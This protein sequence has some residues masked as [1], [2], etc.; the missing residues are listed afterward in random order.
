MRIA[1]TSIAI[2]FLLLSLLVAEE[3]TVLHTPS[4]Q[5]EFWEH[6]LYSTGKSLSCYFTIEIVAREAGDPKNRDRYL[7]DDEEVTSVDEVID[8]VSKN[9]K[10]FTFLKN[11]KNPRIV[12]IIDND[13]RK[14]PDYPIDQ[15]MDLE[16][17][18]SLDELSIAIEKKFPTLGPRRSGEV[19]QFLIADPITEIEIDIKDTTVRDI[20]TDCVPLKGYQPLLWR[21]ETEKIEGKH[22]T[23]LQYYGP[24]RK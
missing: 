7:L 16:Y 11:K 4:N 19:S 3:N 6:Y 24:L 23:I 15:K 1:S 18:G 10:T 13:L 14:I 21:A 12:H 8:K 9:R 17:S 22:K 5:R 20:L 2:V